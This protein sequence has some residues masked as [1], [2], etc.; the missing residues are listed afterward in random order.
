MDFFTKTKTPIFDDLNGSYII[1]SFD[2]AYNISKIIDLVNPD[3]SNHHHRVAYIS[4]AIATAYGLDKK[5]VTDTVIAALI[6]DIGVMLES[7]FKELSKFEITEA[8]K[9]NHS[10]V[11]AFL[12]SKIDTFK[13]LSDIISKHHL[14]YNKFPNTEDEALIIHLAD[15]IDILLKRGTPAYYQKT[16]I[17]NQITHYSGKYFKPEHVE[18]L[19]SIYDREFLWLDIEA[20]DKDRIMKKYFV[21]DTLI[22]DKDEILSFTN[23]LSHIIDFR[24]SFT[25]THSAGVA[26]VA[27]KIGEL[28]GL[29]QYMITN[30]KIAGYLHDLGKLAI[31]PY[32]INKNGSLSLD[33]RIEIKKHT[34]YTF[35]ALNSMDIFENIKEWAAFHHEFLDGSGYPFHLSAERLDIGCRI[36]TVADI[37]TALSED[38]PYRKGM[39]KNQI[40]EILQNLVRDHKIDPEIVDIVVKHFDEIENTR[41]LS[42]LIVSQKYQEFRNILL[43]NNIRQEDGSQDQYMTYNQIKENIGD[44]LNIIHFEEVINS[45]DDLILIL[46]TE[47][48]IVY[49]NK[50]VLTFFNKPLEDILNKKPGEL[51]DCI[52]GAE[53]QCG[54]TQLCKNCA[55]NNALKKAIK[56]VFTVDQ[57]NIEQKN[58]E[59]LHFNISTVPIK[60]DRGDFILFIL[61]NIDEHQRRMIDS[62][63]YHDIIN[64]VGTTFSLLDAHK[65][66]LLQ[67]NADLLDILSSNI[68]LIY[69]EIESQR[70]L[71]MA[72]NNNLHTHFEEFPISFI[73]K[74][75]RNI[76][77]LNNKIT[78]IFEHN[79]DRIFSDKIILNRI[80]LNMVKNAVEAGDQEKIVRIKFIGDEKNYR[81][82]VNNPEFIPE[83]IQSKIF[84]E[85]FTTKKD[86]NGLGTFCIK[87]L[88]EKYLG[89]KVNF[90]STKEHGTTFFIDFPNLSNLL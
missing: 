19:L 58:H 1:S 22:L 36:M 35:Y 62:I 88:T 89:G 70:F 38:R 61:K 10:N 60:T 5:R 13:H 9:L 25:A 41:K 27:S 66:G 7:E 47:R 59:Y 68:S 80:I 21:F 84:K 32:I 75:I 17:K 34:Y 43:I 4:A 53:D 67:I 31:N 11:G 83:E 24:C 42:Q 46:N 90:I 82:S 23:F 40:I 71:S 76:F 74:N 54:T 16:D 64:V 39:E 73:E 14:P 6:H 12:I 49:A 56:G 87:L 79:I 33:E 18:A 81:I 29:P 77:H 8:T 15:R 2:L 57:C 50:R 63:F 48:R 30:L 69:Q 45:I 65:K 44:V 51:F 52:N 28:Y 86:G 37:Y 26:S 3:L 55:G 78:F 72:L 20:P 85:T